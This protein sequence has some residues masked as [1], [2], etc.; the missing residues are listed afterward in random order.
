VHLVADEIVPVLRGETRY[1][2]HVPTSAFY[3]LDDLTFSVLESIRTRGGVRAEELTNGFSEALGAAPEDV[4]E[5]VGD[6][7][8][9]SLLVPHGER[10]MRGPLGD[11]PP[12]H[13]GMANLVLHVAHACNLGCTYCYAEHGLYKGNAEMMTEDRSIEYIDWLFD[14]ADPSTKQLG[15]TFFG[16][17]PMMNMH[18]VRRAAAHARKRSEET[19]ISVRFGMTTNGT[20]VTEDIADFLT[21]IDCLVTVSLDAVGKTN[22]RLRPFHSGKGSYDRVLGRIRPLLARRMCVARATITKV[23]LD[24]VHTVE[25]LLAEGFREVG[26]SAVDAGNPAY[27]L[28]GADYVKLLDGFRVLARRY[29]EEAVEGRRYGFSNIHNIVKAFHLG[30]N[31]DYPCGAGLQMVA[32]APNGKMHLCHRFVGEDDYVLGDV[33]AGGVD[34]DRRKSML[35]VI[36]LDERSDCSSCWARYVCSG[37]CHH[38]NFLFEGDPAKTYTSHCDWLRA[39]YQLGLET[40]TEILERN[41]AFISNYVDP[42]YVCRH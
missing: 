13:D 38:V 31:K 17:E 39:W 19:G 22:D 16:G 32:G 25:T 28:N 41:P 34:Q 18:V 23:N 21:E 12:A 4:E 6:L 37:G 9:L 40:Y 7:R 29:I 8:K 15:V 14:Q 33:T 35:R 27:D 36:N 11:K 24:V 30:H 3:A 20:L 1:A 42:G 2:F 5:A 26:C 10:G